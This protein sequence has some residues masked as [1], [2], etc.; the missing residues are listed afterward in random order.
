MHTRWYRQLWDFLRSREGFGTLLIAAFS[1]IALGVV[2]NIL[3]KLHD[4][5]WF[6]LAVFLVATVIVVLGWI[7]RRERGVGVVIQ[8]FP[9]LPTET[10]RLEA[11]LAASANNHTSTLFLQPKLLQPGA[12]PLT[13][14]ARAD[15][16]ANLIDAR[17]AEYT[18]NGR[19]GDLT[20]YPLAQMRDG[21]ILGQRLAEDRAKTF[22]VMHVSANHHTVLPA[23]NLGSHLTQPLPPVQQVL[24]DNCLKQPVAPVV[25]V[26]HPNCPPEHKHRLAFIVRLSRADT[27][28][29]DARHVAETGQPRLPN[30]RHTGYIF[31]KDHPD[32]ATSP[33]GAHV[34]VE[35]STDYLPETQETFEAVATHLYRTWADARD[36]WK[37]QSHSSDIATSLFI[38]APLPI[39]IALGWLMSRA[40]AEVAHHEFGVTRQSTPIEETS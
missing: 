4:S 19:D 31:D 23:V 10:A 11:L 35:A 12:E 21:F 6:F 36:K 16:V 13:P 22:T 15:L 34:I 18:R 30:R 32:A 1:A 20:L 8:M 9:L 28:T 40:H 29:D 33:C 27:M 3:Q 5:G 25:P 39:T 38:M 26:A 37:A 7:L 2:P 14:A 24:L 17:M